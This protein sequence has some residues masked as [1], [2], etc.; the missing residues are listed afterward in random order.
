M[1][2]EDARERREP[3]HDAAEPDAEADDPA[4]RMVHWRARLTLTAALEEKQCTRESAVIS[5]CGIT[6]LE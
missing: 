2:S 1:A 5:Q 3:S 6:A 4:D